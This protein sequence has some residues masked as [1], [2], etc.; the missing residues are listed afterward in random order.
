MRI[1]GGLILICRG[2]ARLCVAAT[3]EQ[4]KL[5]LT[6][7]WNLPFFRIHII[8]TFLFPHT[9]IYITGHADIKIVSAGN[10]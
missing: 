1:S 4:G 6:T 8:A 7:F 2:L 9:Y 3:A 5:T 10:F